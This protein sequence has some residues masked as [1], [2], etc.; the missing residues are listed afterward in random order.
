V[1]V[2]IVGGGVIVGGT[3]VGSSGGAR[4][5]VG[6]E[7]AVAGGGVADGATLAVAVGS[8][9]SSARSIAAPLNCAASGVAVPHGPIATGALFVTAEEATPL[10]VTV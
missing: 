8:S 6:S 4:V 3:A 1:A 5:A 9:S 10:T 7:V 2:S